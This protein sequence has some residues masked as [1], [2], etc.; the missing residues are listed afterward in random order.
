MYEPQSLHWHHDQVSV[1][2]HLKVDGDKSYNPYF[3]DS[4]RHDQVS[5]KQAM[6]ETVKDV[7]LKDD[8]KMIIIK[9]DNCNSQ[10]KSA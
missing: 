1:Q 6:D 10:Y 5:V 4:L 9:T 7:D 3:F 8:N 2:S